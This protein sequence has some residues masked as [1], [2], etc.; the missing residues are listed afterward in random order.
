MVFIAVFFVH[1]GYGPAGLSLLT[2]VFE[3]KLIAAGFIPLLVHCEI[4]PR[5]FAK[6]KL[7]VTVNGHQVVVWV[8]LPN[9]SSHLV[10]PG[11]IAKQV[12]FIGDIP[13]HV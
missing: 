7:T 11:L 1:L 9:K 4:G 13:H 2:A 5:R 6:R 12:V 10:G 3:H 8:A